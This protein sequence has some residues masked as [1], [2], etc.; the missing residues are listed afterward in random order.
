[1]GRVAL[2][3]I[4]GEIEA[5]RSQQ[6]ASTAVC[7]GLRQCKVSERTSIVKFAPAGA[8]RLRALLNVVGSDFQGGDKVGTLHDMRF[9]FLDNDTKLLFAT[10]YDRDP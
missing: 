3:K 10:T 5:V 6:K 7:T 1:M 2:E 4:M 8:K 9:V